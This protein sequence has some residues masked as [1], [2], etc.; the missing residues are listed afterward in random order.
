M[1]HGPGVQVVAKVP[2]DGPGAAAEQRG[3]ARHQRVVDL[4]RADEMDVAVEP[5]RGEDA[6]LARDHVGAGPDDDRDVRLDVRIAGL[7]DRMD[8]AVLD[9]DVA[10]HDP[11]VI[12]DDRV[13]DDGIDRALLVGH[14]R[15][16]HAVADHLAAAEL[17]LL[18]I[19]GEILLHLDDEIGVGEPHAVALGGAEHVGIDRAGHLDGMVR[20]PSARAQAAAG[21]SVEK[22]SSTGLRRPAL[23]ARA[24]RA[25]GADRPSRARN[26]ASRDSSV[27]TRPA[28]SPSRVCKIDLDGLRDLEPARVGDLVLELPARAAAWRFGDLRQV[29]RSCAT[30]SLIRLAPRRCPA[31]AGCRSSVRARGRATSIMFFGSL[32]GQRKEVHHH[33]QAIDLVV[34]GERLDRVAERRVVD[35]AAVPI[36]L[37]RR[38]SS[39]ETAAPGCRSP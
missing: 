37:R 25:R 30:S 28:A 20:S 34:V 9:A 2:C 7:A 39:R 17:H 15:L 35:D 23:R 4:L 5:A 19:G 12:E 31:A 13:G 10:L 26:R 33:E 18:A 16:P 8:L 32:A 3:H 29:R 14:L 24:S 6:P 38:S 1:C 21:G 36:E 11:P 22:C 27:D